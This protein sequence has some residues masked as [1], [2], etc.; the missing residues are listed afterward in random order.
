MDNGWIKLHRRIQKSDVYKTL[1][2]VQ[3]DVMIQCLLLANHEPHSWEW[4]DKIYEVVEGE[5][6][7]S[8]KSL[9]KVCAKGVSVQNI[10]TSLDK[11]EK[12][13]FLTNKSTKTGRL[14]K[15]VNWAKYQSKDTKTNKVTNKQL[16][17]NQQSTNKA[18]TT[19]KK[20]KND[21][22]SK[23]VYASYKEKINESSRLTDKAKDKIK[24]RLK[25]FSVLD[26]IRAVENFSLDDWWMEKNANRGVAWFF[27]SDDRIDGFITMVPR[28][29]LYKSPDGRTFKSRIK[30][31]EYCKSKGWGVTTE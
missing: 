11:L 10:R 27:N 23:E 22:E 19:N 12:W 15:I 28:G 8:L 31:A 3:R 2:A 30:W 9:K 14:I 17:K 29:D 5:F 4:Q 20:D 24:A 21:K 25:S 7:T 6:I 16:T 26:L 18:L 13:S 1:N